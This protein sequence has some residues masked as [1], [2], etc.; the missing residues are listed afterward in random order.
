M[1]AEKPAQE[2]QEVPEG[3]LLVLHTNKDQRVFR[4]IQVETKRVFLNYCQKR[5]TQTIIISLNLEE[6]KL[7]IMNVKFRALNYYF[8]RK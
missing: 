6:M 5:V 7:I 4:G 3:P 1:K 8:Q 2:S